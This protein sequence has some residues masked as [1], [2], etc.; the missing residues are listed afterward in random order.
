MLKKQDTSFNTSENKETVVEYYQQPQHLKIAS[1]KNYNLGQSAINDFDTAQLTRSHST[2]NVK[3]NVEFK[4]S[5]VK[6]D[7]SKPFI[8]E[9]DQEDAHLNNKNYD[10]HEEY[11][12]RSFQSKMDEHPHSTNQLHIDDIV[13]RK[14]HNVQS[15]PLRVR[16]YSNHRKFNSKQD[17]YEGFPLSTSENHV[18]RTNKVSQ[19]QYSE[20]DSSSKV[21]E[22]FK[23]NTQSQS[24]IQEPLDDLLNLVHNPREWVNIQ[25]V[26]RICFS[27]VCQKLTQQEE[28]IKYLHAELHQKPSMNDVYAIVDSKAD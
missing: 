5:E 16:T 20:R 3:K 6:A 27:Q 23:A 15:Q 13:E 10:I 2:I 7:H 24:Q 11:T 14:P 4:Q 9:E 17:I 28:H 8:K 25:D 22:P 21:E 12:N 19:R 18:Y 1:T 26:V